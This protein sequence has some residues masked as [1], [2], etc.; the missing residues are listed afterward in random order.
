MICGVGVEGC[1]YGDDNHYHCAKCN[2]VTGMMG[3][4]AGKDKPF[5][6]KRPDYKLQDWQLFPVNLYD[7]DEKMK[8]LQEQHDA[9]RLL[10]YYIDLPGGFHRSGGGEAL[11]NARR[12]VAEDIDAKL[13]DDEVE[14]LRTR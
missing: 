1:P 10:L 14:R 8:K 2:G 4:Y 3:H 6:C 12:L 11:A 7:D 13:A 5:T 9:L